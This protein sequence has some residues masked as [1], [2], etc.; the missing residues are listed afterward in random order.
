MIKE[1]QRYQQLN[2]QGKLDGRAEFCFLNP[3]NKGAR[4]ISRGRLFHRQVVTTKK[5]QLLV[6]SLWASFTV[7][8]LN[9]PGC[10]EWVLLT[11]LAGSRHSARYQD[12]KLFT[13]LNVISVTLKSMRK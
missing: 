3:S 7:K 4:H 13:A 12:P 8:A 10:E 2:A 6:V 5:A 11:D 9:H 1:K